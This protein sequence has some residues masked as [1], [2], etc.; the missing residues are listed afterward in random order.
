MRY[1]LELESGSL[2]YGWDHALGFWG[3]HLD[4][5]GREI[6]NYDAISSGY[7]HARPLHGLLLFLGRIS[8]MF[9]EDD[10]S[11]SAILMVHTMPED[12]PDHLLA[13]GS[14]IE[15]L[16]RAADQGREE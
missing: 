10:I 1:K 4:E 3:E 11:E 5:R 13:V 8:E 7:D 16:R 2:I 14:V 9:G 6:E 15:N 12:L